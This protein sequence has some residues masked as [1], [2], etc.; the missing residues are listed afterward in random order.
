[1]AAEVTK[2]KITVFIAVCQRCS[3][4]VAAECIDYLD[5]H[6]GRDMAE[7]GGLVLRAINRGNRLEIVHEP[8]SIG[9]CQCWSS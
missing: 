7:F 3:N 8:V 1:M 5:A 6:D 4:V 9:A 2:N